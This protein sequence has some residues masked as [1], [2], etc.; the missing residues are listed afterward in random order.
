MTPCLPSEQIFNALRIEQPQPDPLELRGLQSG[1][2]R[3]SGGRDPA[4]PFFDQAANYLHLTFHATLDAFRRLA[5]G[6]PFQYPPHDF[7][8]FTQS[9][10]H[11]QYVVPWIRSGKSF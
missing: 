1:Q 10:Q 4:K 8:V 5:R 6:N 3:S 7:R 9:R 11:G 2:S